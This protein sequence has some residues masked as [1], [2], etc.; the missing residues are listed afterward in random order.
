MKLNKKLGQ[1][2]STL[3]K[4]EKLNFDQLIT[5]EETNRYIIVHFGQGTEDDYNVVKKFI[6]EF[7]VDE[8][9]FVLD[10]YPGYPH[11]FLSFNSA[12]IAHRLNSY[13][14]QT[15]LNELKEM[16]DKKD[17]KENEKQEALSQDK[18]EKESVPKK[19]A[20]PLE[21]G[22][23]DEHRKLFTKSFELP[24]E[25][26]SRHC[27]FFNT[28]LKAED[29]KC[30]SAQSNSLHAAT[31]DYESLLQ[32][33]LIVIEDVITQNEEATILDEIHSKEWENLSHRRV[34]HYGY[35]FIY[36]ANS[37]DKDKMIGQLPTWA[38]QLFNKPKFESLYESIKISNEKFKI[39]SLK[40]Q[41]ECIQLEEDPKKV[42]VSI[43]NTSDD[44]IDKN[45]ESMQ[46]SQ[47]DQNCSFGSYFDQLTINEYQPGSGIPPHTDSH[48]P[49]EEALISIS[50]L[51]DIVMTFRNPI[52]NV[53]TN[54]LIPAR[55][56]FILTGESRYLWTHSIS[57]RKIDRVQ[58]GLLF[59]RRRVSLTYRK[60][61][62]VPFCDCPYKDQCDFILDKK[63]AK[64]KEEIDITKPE[65]EKKYVK[66]VYN[67]IAEHFSHTRYKAWPSVHAFLKSLPQGS[68]VGDIGCGNGKYMFCVDHLQFVGSD[69]AENFA[70]I[71]KDKDKLIQVLV[72]D[73]TNVP[74]RDSS[75][76]HAISIA[77]IH[78]LSTADRRKH[79]IKELLRV[80]KPNGRV[81]IYVWAYEQDDKKF[82]DQDVF[83]PWNNQA[84]FEPKTQPSDIEKKINEAKQTIVYQRFY[85]V[86]KKGELEELI[87]EIQKE[88]SI[89]I[90]VLNSYYDHEN[91]C[92]ELCKKNLQHSA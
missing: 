66:D 52:T 32:H 73:T 64:V 91:W 13:I 12:D 14:H 22:F 61:R 48:A 80:V 75:L 25:A 15:Y 21:R 34:Q 85:H 62:E 28:L 71:C 50:L 8:S 81:L 23:S 2:I 27:F 11:G 90:E 67:S 77:V 57:T 24:F 79:A 88:M 87:N 53:E 56:A 40:S 35:K 49:F 19:E 51:S 42:E 82:V 59:R 86:F 84:K 63:S 5:D 54:V 55:S 44:K 1:A 58:S 68:I 4:V 10:L 39:E 6:L 33:G 16:Q 72:S 46:L 30:F 65:F 18:I 60:S 3:T 26:R 45:I 83:V 47:K 7:G 36:G 20:N 29:M 74:F 89:Q 38:T 9:K 31:S 70:K 41:A 92:I 17:K 37:I 78:H 76:D 43:P 69:I